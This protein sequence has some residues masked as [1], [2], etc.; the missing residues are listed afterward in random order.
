MITIK[1][2]SAPRR[3][4]TSWISLYCRT[5]L[6]LTFQHALVGLVDPLDG[7]A[8]DVGDDAVLGAEVEHLL[9]LRDAA[10]QRAGD[11]P[12]LEDQV[13]HVRRRVGVLGHADQA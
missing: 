4:P 1:L 12:P 2:A 8:L 5:S 10:D 11:R 13:A 3:A 7:D 6:H 9:G